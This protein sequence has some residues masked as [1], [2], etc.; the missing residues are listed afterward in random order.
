MIIRYSRAYAPTGKIYALRR[1]GNL[2]ERLTA[3][4]REPARL[5]VSGAPEGFDS[6]IVVEA[7]KRSGG[8][9]VFVAADDARA[10]AAL[11]TARFFAPDLPVLHFPA[12]D[13]LPYDRVSPRSDIESRRLAT[14]AAL[15]SEDYKKNPALVVTTVNAVVQRVPPRATIAEASFLVKAGAVVDLEALTRFLARN[16]YIRTGTVREPG[17]YAPRG[18][19]VDLWPPGSD[20]PLRL[21]FFGAQLETIKHFDAET[22]R[23]ADAVN[24]AE[25][26]PA[27]EAP[28][29][30]DT[31]S[32]FRSGYVAAFGAVTD[33]DPLY[34]AVSAGRKHAGM[35]HWLPLFHETMETLFDYT[36]RVPTFFSS[37]AAE[38]LKARLELVADYYATRKSMREAESGN[39]LRKGAPFAAP[40]KPLNPDAL[41]L[42]QAEWEKAYSSRVARVFSPFTAPDSIN[43]LDAGGRS[44]RDFAPERAQEGKEGARVNV[45][46]A[47]AGHLKGLQKL[48][49]RV[50]VACW[51]K[52]SAERMGGVLS[53]HGLTAIKRISDWN[54]ALTLHES[55]VGLGVLGLEHGFDG[56]E[57]AIVTEQDVL[58]DRMVR[59][60]GRQRR[61]KNFLAEASSLSAGDLVTHIEH[62]VGRYVGLKTIEV[63]GAPHGCLELHYDGGKLFLPVENIEL[64]TRYGSEESS[65]QLDKLGGLGWQSRKAKMKERVREIAAELIRIAASRTLKKTSPVETPAGAYDEFSARFPYQETEDQ[66][67][68]ISDVIA[69]FGK[70]QPMDR[71]VCGDVGF[72]KTEVALRAA[73]VM[74]MSGQQVAVVV[75]TTLLA[76]QH[77]KNFTERFSGLPIKIG[78]LSRF[79]TAKEVAFAKEGLASGKLDIVVGTHALLAKSISFK[80]LGLLIVDEEQ[81][82][83]VSHKEQLKSIKSG[84]HVLTLT[85]TPIPRTLQLALSGVRDLSLITTAP[86]DR[87]AVRTYVTP[88]D[89]LILREA[90]LREHYRG[91]Q[92][93]YVVPRISDLRDATEFLK[94]TVPEL[95][96]T[97]AHGQM[98]TSQLED[99]MTSFYDGQV[100]VLISTNIVESGLDIPTA[101]TLIVHRADRFG[102]SQL[103]QLRGRV[104]RSK[105]R[106][107]AYL[108]TPT[109]SKITDS[110]ERRLHVLQSL[111]T[112]GAGFS[113]A[114]HDLDLRGAGNLVGDEQTGHIREVGIELYQ[115][116]L[117][118]AVSSLR[119]G[120]EG[121]G[122]EAWSPQI[123][124]GAPVLI[125][126]EYVPD[127]NV[128]MSLYR[129]L[130][131]LENKADLDGFAAELIDR[132]GPIPEEVENLVKIVAIKQLCRAAGVEKIDAGP[133]GATI[134]FRNNSFA[135]PAGLIAFI[136]DDPKSMRVR[137][138]QTLVAIRDWPDAD[139]R[140]KG[141]NRVLTHLAEIAA[142]A[143]A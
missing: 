55:A 97:V 126:E 13:C 48:G 49:K 51:S 3:I 100:D 121:D 61:S 35:E 91:G 92:S 82:F 22:Q 140:M 18:G 37:Q 19:I 125:P 143:Q 20:D 15:A 46:E 123:S 84:V 78:Q 8:L 73:F 62:G 75:P 98:P 106:A 96:Y 59:S 4:A 101:N 90:L 50:V 142:E 69:D 112:L 115:A 85:A 95:K 130:S 32:R 88:F 102:L 116:M 43:A 119:T 65:V 110:A 86:I 113:I 27:S 109:D 133:K 47:A 30:P 29:D 60:R 108:T 137:P 40:Y 57:F 68:A 64:L 52:G 124:V 21:D 135:N 114:S 131:E 83:G 111:D 26:L 138:D 122:E 5:S 1:N 7:A 45:F 72:G 89:P 120:G 63:T 118:E 56:P 107:Y 54:E 128:R 79:A 93:F 127:L 24:S 12:W 2:V 28:L 16:A 80:S 103:Y 94:E 33:E 14:L 134:A 77:Y 67:R 36:G 76:R 42:S 41:Y 70:G 6:Y 23:S 34:A 132:F 136:T 141:I 129:R 53:D 38:A 25:L 139:H 71:L 58:G 117:E 31:I 105:Q 10:N 81:H 39:P 74:A 104:G 17:E 66:D 9:V 99:A 44:G 11:E 87:L